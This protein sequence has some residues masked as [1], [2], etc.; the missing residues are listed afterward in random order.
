MT[1]LLLWGGA[2]AAASPQDK[3]EAAK[4]ATA[5][6]YGFCRLKAEAKAIKT[7]SALDVSKCDDGYAA[8]WNQ[9]EAKSGGACPTSGDLSQIQ[10]LIAQHTGDVA[11]ALAGGGLP[12][13]PADLAACLAQPTG[14]RLQTGQTI[15]YDNFLGNPIACSGTAQDGELKKGLTRVYV[16]N[17]DG[18]ITD[19]RTGLMWEKLSD[20]G[21]IH[22]RDNVYTWG[23]AKTAALN[24]ASF[25]GHNDW[26]LPNVNELQSLVQYGTVL[27]AVDAPFNTGCNPAC[28]VTT[29]SC[30]SATYYWSSTT[31]TNNPS[32]AWTVDFNVGGVS[33]EFKVT[34]YS[35]RA[36]R[37]GL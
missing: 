18:T 22:D 6:K 12:Q 27:P 23:T 35:V 16:D 3:C 24:T 36:V 2:A 21:S 4:V 8:K 26:R 15:C 1:I 17:G 7:G 10:S 33:P 31:S 11:T 29:C 37:D 30:T 5:G 25:A 28:T 32:D 9:T 20:D 19:T 14:R 13:C 34:N